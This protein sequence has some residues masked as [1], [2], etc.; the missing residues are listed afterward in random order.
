MEFTHLSMTIPVDLEIT[1]YRIHSEDGGVEIWGYVG[2]Y[3]ICLCLPLEEANARFLKKIGQQAT[4]RR[5]AT[6]RS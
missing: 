1:R 3:E 6:K 4:A 5:K 2:D